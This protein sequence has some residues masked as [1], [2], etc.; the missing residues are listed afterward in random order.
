M[1]LVYFYL[2][3]LKSLEKKSLTGSTFDVQLGTTFI[4]GWRAIWVYHLKSLQYDAFL[5]IKNVSADF[6]MSRCFWENKENVFTCDT[7][8]QQMTAKI[9]KPLKSRFIWHG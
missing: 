4:Y 9:Q 3:K 1:F 7:C 2:E 5:L 6:Q 8:S